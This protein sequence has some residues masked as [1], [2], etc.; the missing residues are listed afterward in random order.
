MNEQFGALIPAF[1][2]AGHI[3]DV[4]RGVSEQIPP[5]N[6]LVI[7]DG[8]TDGTVSE[9]EATGVRLLRN[10]S[11]MGKGATLLKG[12]G[13]MAEEPRIEGVFTLDADGQ[14]DP[15]EMPA[16]MAAF[17]DDGADIVIGSRMGDVEGM[18]GIRRFTNR[19]TSMVISILA[20]TRVEDSQSGYRLIRLSILEKLHLV[21][22]NFDMESE[23]IIK[24]ARLGAEIV[25]VPITTIYGEEESKI[26]PTVDTLRFLRLVFRSF[27]W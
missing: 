25:S 4:I 15:A 8:S 13:L 19:F 27:L 10:P 2:E 9:V 18:P 11:N 24:A 5:S 3:G 14:H 26:N 20:G 16:F 21:T 7:D 6:I 23:M 1:N 17:V 12:F 22:R